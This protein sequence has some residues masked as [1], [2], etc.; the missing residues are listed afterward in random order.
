[1]MNTS[2]TLPGYAELHCLSNFTFLQGASHP[3]ELVERAIELGYSALALTDECSVA[4]VVRA[5]EAVETLRRKAADDK[6]SFRF[7]LIIGTQVGLQ[8]GLRLVLLAASRTGY[9]HLCSLITRGRLNSR[10]GT[11][12]L[13]RTDL[14]KGMDDCLALLVPGTGTTVEDAH[15]LSQHFP[16]RTWIATEL[17]CGPDDRLKLTGLRELSRA[18][19]LPLAAAGDVHM[20]VRSRRRLQDILTAIRLGKPVRRCGHALYPNGERHL[21]LRSRLSRLY[22]P[23]LLIETLRIAERCNFSYM[24]SPPSTTRD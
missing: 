19:G 4:G 13:A 18:S 22:P 1:M 16:E 23:E 8:D 5:H 20:H 10:K 21:R 3:Q 15:W 14:E 24:D 7:Q 9:G 11:Y 2:I 12:A 6:T 17:H